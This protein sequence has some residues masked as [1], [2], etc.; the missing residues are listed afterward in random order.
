MRKG[1]SKQKQMSKKKYNDKGENFYYPNDEDRIAIINKENN[2]ESNNAKF[3]KRIKKGDSIRY[4]NDNKQFST[5]DNTLSINNINNID[6]IIPNFLVQHNNNIS[7]AEIGTWIR[8]KNI[9]IYHTMDSIKENNNRN[10]NN[11]IN[12][13]INKNNNE[14]INENIITLDDKNNNKDIFNDDIFSDISDEG[15]YIKNIREEIIS[16]IGKK[17]DELR[18]N[19]DFNIYDESKIIQTFKKKIFKT[20]LKIMKNAENF[21]RKRK[22]NKSKKKQIINIVYYY[23]INEYDYIL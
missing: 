14:N 23:F 16:E 8:N 10:I 18:F 2:Y 11:N 12:E 5:F 7:M 9:M 21:K 15:S 22:R 19:N 13:N 20:K 4:E 1:N 6:N 17:N 3:R